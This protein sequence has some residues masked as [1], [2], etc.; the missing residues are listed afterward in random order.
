MPEGHT[1]H[2]LARD[3]TELV[4][5]TVSASSPQGRFPAEPI[6]GQ[7][8]AGIEAYGKNLLIDTRDGDSVHVH[9]GMRGK[10]LRFAPV[11]GPGL[12]QVRLRFAV[13]DVA[14]DLIAPS[15]CELLDAADR[16]ALVVGLG[17]DPLRPDA[18]AELA[19]RLV[20]AHPG[21]IGAA[22]LDQSRIAGVGNV[23]RAEVLHGMGMAPTRPAR[24]VTSEE[25]AQLWARLQAMMS[26]AVEDG[27]I[28]TVDA[29]DRLAVPEAEARRVYKREHCDDCGTPVVTGTIEGR[30][31][32]AC[33]RCQ[34]D[35][36]G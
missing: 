6:D 17:P 18:D 16:D 32:Y 34:P 3:M 33:P 30:T 11:T 5:P 1:L 28:I 10:W 25:F 15:R 29:V 9:L 13:P 21:T 4:G 22:L 26:R 20:S 14:W 8:L 12:P 7:R 19:Y 27:R 36:A 23:F 35:R 31:T 2:R 24:S